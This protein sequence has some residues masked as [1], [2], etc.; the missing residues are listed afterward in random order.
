MT[1]LS[2]LAANKSVVRTP[3]KAFD[4]ISRHPQ[5]IPPLFTRTTPLL[6]AWGVTTA[7]ATLS[8]AALTAK[9]WIRMDSDNSNNNKRER[10]RERERERCC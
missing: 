3:T 4:D 8:K 7:K 10:E 5:T 1:N 9:P 6:I 2:K